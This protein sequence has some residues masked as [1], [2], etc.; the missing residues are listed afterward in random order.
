MAEQSIG[1]RIKFLIE[2]TEFSVRKFAQTID[3]SETNIRNYIDRGTKPSSDVLEKIALQFPQTNLEWLLTGNGA[4]LRTDPDG[5]LTQTNISGKK[6]AVNV[7]GG[8]ANQTNIILSECEKERDAYKAQ[9][10][11]A[12]SENELL[13][14]QLK[15]QESII[16]AKE[17]TISLL[18]ASFNRPN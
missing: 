11:K 12:V 10:D 16:A 15:M 4:P 17:E 3:V 9:L 1:Q 8:K 13:R 18:R 7:A 6:N 5:E 2:A 14:G